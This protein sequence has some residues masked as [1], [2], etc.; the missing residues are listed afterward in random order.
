MQLDCTNTE[1][2]LT[3]LD[4][5]TESK[6]MRLHNIEQFQ[7][8]GEETLNTLVK[9]YSSQD[10]T[11]LKSVILT[12]RKVAQNSELNR[13][14]NKIDVLLSELDNDTVPNLEA[15]QSLVNLVEVNIHEA[16]RI[17]DHQQGK[18]PPISTISPN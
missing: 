14:I 9:V 1:A 15:M 12:L 17:L 11:G 2:E 18:R 16:I 8:I 3:L 5:T 6:Q 13:I 7:S 4:S 10:V